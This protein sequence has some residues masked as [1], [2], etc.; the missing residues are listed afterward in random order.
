MFIKESADPVGKVHKIEAVEALLETYMRLWDEGAKKR[1]FWKVRFD[2]SRITN[3]LMRA[4]DDFIV[5]VDDAGILG[6]DKKATVLLATSKLYD[7]VVKE[8]MPLWLA[9]F[10]WTIKQYVIYVLVSNAIDWL[11]SKYQGGWKPRAMMS[12]EVRKAPCRRKR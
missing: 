2:A 5:A 1:S 12:W 11:V 10:A 8:G 7:Y 4:L 3:F 6:P 9:P